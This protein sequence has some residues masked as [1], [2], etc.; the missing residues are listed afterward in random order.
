MVKKNIGSIFI[1]YLRGVRS[2]QRIYLGGGPLFPPCVRQLF[3]T[4]YSRLSPSSIHSSL[5]SSTGIMGT[6]FCALL[7]IGSGVLNSGPHVCEMT[8]LSPGPSP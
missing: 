5:G 1:F 7:H 4:V 2:D 6:Y 8:T 3:D